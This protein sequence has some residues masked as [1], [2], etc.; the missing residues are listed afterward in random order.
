MR[1]I[2][3]AFHVGKIFPNG[4]GDIVLLLARKFLRFQQSHARAIGR[5]RPRI[6]IGFG[7]NGR[8][9]AIDLGEREEASKR[10][11]LAIAYDDHN[12]PSLKLSRAMALAGKGEYE[13]AGAQA[14]ELVKQEKL[15]ETLY[16]LAGVYALSSSAASGAK[17]QTL[18]HSFRS[19]SMET[20]ER[21]KEAGYFK[22]AA[23]VTKMEKDT[24]FDGVR[25]TEEFKRFSAE[26]TATK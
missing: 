3:I 4:Q 10:W 22:D 20:L 6:E 17:N 26:L 8:L 19:K 2:R 11:G 18:A 23:H 12:D 14:D 9:L 5:L 21:V 13:K 16:R 1:P 7:L 24:A 25:N 15:P